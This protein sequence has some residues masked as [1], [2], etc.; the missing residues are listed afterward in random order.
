VPI[1]WGLAVLLNEWNEVSTDRAWLAGMAGV[2]P[3]PIGARAID[4]G[5]RRLGCDDDDGDIARAV[6]R[7]VDAVDLERLRPKS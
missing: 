6:W 1:P 5:I 4:D 2:H 7:T 3:L